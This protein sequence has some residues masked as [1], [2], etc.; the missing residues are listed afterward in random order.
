[1]GECSEVLRA[2]FPEYDAGS[3]VQ[4][5]CRD[6]GWCV[7]KPCLAREQKPACIRQRA[8]AT[9]LARKRLAGT[10]VPVMDEGVIRESCRV[11]TVPRQPCQGPFQLGRADPDRLRLSAAQCGHQARR[12][13]VGHAAPLDRENEHTLP[14]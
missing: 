1:M 7:H 8:E 12:R 3:R 9:E 11:G 6:S 4:Q 14:G 13:R 2:S 5:G 10:P